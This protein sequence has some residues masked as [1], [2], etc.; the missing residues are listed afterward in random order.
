MITLTDAR[1]LLKKAV[2][3]QGPDFVYNPDGAYLCR[4]EPIPDDEG[5]RPEDPR[6][7]TGCLVGVALDIAG[8]TAHHGFA[9]SVSGLAREGLVRME[10]EAVWYLGKAQYAQDRGTSWGDA[11]A[12]AEASLERK[13]EPTK[14]VWLA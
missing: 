9:G 5:M 13:P 14:A 7:K 1:D 4:Y 6:S 3:T 11:L 12:L 2:D 8:I 10:D